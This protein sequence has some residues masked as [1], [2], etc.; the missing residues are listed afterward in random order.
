[1]RS[2][3]LLRLPAMLAGISLLA[4]SLLALSLPAGAASAASAVA[5][6]PAGITGDGNTPSDGD[7]AV[8]ANDIVQVE[9]SEIGIWSK[10]DLTKP[11][12]QESL[13]MFQG[14]AAKDNNCGDPRIVYMPLNQRWAF[15]CAEDLPSPDAGISLAVSQ[16]SDPAGPWY[17]WV[18]R[19][20]TH[21]CFAD[22]PKLMVTSDKLILF[23]PSSGSIDTTCPTPPTT[24]DDIFQ[25][26]PLA[27]LL[28][29]TITTPTVVDAKTSADHLAGIYQNAA[30]VQ[31]DGY[32][33]GN[34]CAGN[35]TSDCLD[36][37]E[38]SGPPSSPTVTDSRLRRARAGTRLV[39]P[40]AS[41]PCGRD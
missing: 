41:E 20:A 5:V 40:R 32:F 34:D 10:T 6:P 16:T 27:S 37:L 36:L 26:F 4:A 38:V 1:M 21:M 7:I 3:S 13:R 30:S 15:S 39:R 25:V 2:K 33:V 31:A 18:G 23:T 9:N 35:R 19:A 11:V 14:P 28:A 8:G 24:T 17:S 22:Q 29:G 12:V